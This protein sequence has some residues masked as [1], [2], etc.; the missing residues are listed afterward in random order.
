MFFCISN[1]NSNG[2]APYM[3]KLGASGTFGNGNT[4]NNI[5]GGNYKVYI[6]EA[7]GYIGN[8]TAVVGQPALVTAT[9]TKTDE[10]CPSSHDGE[11]VATGTGGTP[12]YQYKL[13]SY[14]IYGNS[15]TFTGLVGGN[16]KVYAKDVNGCQGV[17]AVIA[18]LVTS[19]PCHP[20]LPKAGLVKK[21]SETD[22]PFN[23]W[24]LPNPS[25]NQFSL[26]AHSGSALP[27]S[28][29]ILDASGRSVY[30]GKGQAEQT[31]SFGD[32]FA[33][34]LYLVEVRQGDKVQV[35]KAVKAK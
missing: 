13:N 7:N 17:S 30:S 21:I 6:Q 2:A 22:K 27:V 20:P 29:R 15:N 8:I 18:I 23:I 34:G 5:K 10:T 3:Y 19:D 25:S 26:T 1:G 31:F 16:Y 9:F 33:K 35:V 28:V 4:F 24:L 11:I 32:K 12:P 14:G